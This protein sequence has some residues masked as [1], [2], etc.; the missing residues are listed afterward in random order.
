MLLS[1]RRRP[2]GEAVNAC[3]RL[4]PPHS[5]CSKETLAGLKLFSPRPSLLAIPPPLSLPS[6]TPDC[7]WQM[8]LLAPYHQVWRR[9]PKTILLCPYTATVPP[10]RR[11]PYHFAWLTHLLLQRF[12]GGQ[13]LCQW[14]GFVIHRFTW[15]REASSSDTVASVTVKLRCSRIMWNLL[16]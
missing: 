10:P 16:Y 13:G 14:S 3:F 12:K 6:I 8:P 15:Q 4:C 2:Q 11:R 9:Q 1:E 7:I 5:W